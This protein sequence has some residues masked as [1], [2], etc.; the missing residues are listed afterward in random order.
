MSLENCVICG[1]PLEVTRSSILNG[2]DY[3][4]SN[5]LF[6]LEHLACAA[7]CRYQRIEDL[8]VSL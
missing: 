5:G 4:G 6:T 1:A 2:V 8:T 3:D 7:G